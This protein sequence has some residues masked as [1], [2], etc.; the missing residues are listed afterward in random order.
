[1]DLA[2][3]A[4]SQTGRRNS[5]N[6]EQFAQHQKH[7]EYVVVLSQLDHENDFLSLKSASNIILQFELILKRCFFEINHVLLG[8]QAILPIIY[9]AILLFEFIQLLFFIFY[10]V[11]VVNEFTY[12]SYY[13]DLEGVSNQTN[14]STTIDADAKFSTFRIDYYFA[15]TNFHMYILQQQSKDAFM[16]FHIVITV[17]FLLYVISI[18]TLSKQIFKDERNDSLKEGMKYLVKFFSILMTV[19]LFILQI[20]MITIYLQG[21]LCEEDESQPYTLIGLKCYSL[22]HQLYIAFSTISLCLYILFLIIQSL[23]FTSNS[24]E[25]S[26]PWGSL[27]RRLSIMRVLVK[28]ILACCF[29]WDKQ[30]K[31]RGP[32]NLVCFILCSFLVYHRY[33][34]AIVFKQSVYYAMMI[35]EVQQMWLFLCISVHILGDQKLNIVGFGLLMISGFIFG[36]IFIILTK[37][38]TELMLRKDISQFKHVYEIE[39]YLF[40]I[41]ELIRNNTTND[42]FILHGILCNHMQ[43]CTNEKCPCINIME[44][45]DN[46]KVNQA[47]GREPIMQQFDNDINDAN[48]DKIA[49]QG[50]R[51]K[52]NDQSTK[53]F[54]TM[55]GSGRVIG[56]QNRLTINGISMNARTRRNIKVQSQGAWNDKK[57]QE[58]ALSER[59]KKKQEIQWYRFLG[60]LIE[61]AIEKFPKNLELKIINALIQNKK[62]KNEFKAI[63]EL[64]NCE[65][66]N[67]N[68][69]DQFVIF[70]RKIQ[71]ELLLKKNHQKNILEIGRIDIV[72][73]FKYE[74]YFQQYSLLEYKTAYAALLFWR[75]LLQKNV[76]SNVLQERGAEISENYQKIQELANKLIQIYPLEIKFYFR[77]G[78]FLYQ[79]INNAYDALTYFEKIYYTYHGKMSKKAIPVNEMSIFGENSN[80]AIIMISATS[81]KTGNIIHVNDEVETILGYKKQEL[82]H[83]NVSIMMPKPIAKIHDKFIDRYFDTAQPTVIDI[84]RQLFGCTNTG[85]LRTIRLLVKVYPHLSSRL[86][87]V[88]FIQHMDKFE[89]MAQPKLEYQHADFQ[90]LITDTDQNITNVTEGLNLE[91]GLNSKFFQ[92]SDS[93]FEILFNFQKICPEITQE[94]VQEALEE[95]GLILTIDTKN[96]LNHIELESLS[97]DEILEIRSKLGR[98]E[99]YVQMKSLVLDK[100]FCTVHIY[101]ICILNKVNESQIFSSFVKAMVSRLDEDPTD[102]GQISVMQGTASAELE[103]LI[104]QPSQLSL[105]STTSGTYG[106]NKIIKDFKKALG[107]RKTPRNLIYLNRLMVLF[108]TLNMIL[109]GVDFGLKQSNIENYD[110]NNQQVL[111]IQNRILA[112]IHMVSNFRSLINIANGVEFDYYD[113]RLTNSAND[114][115]MTSNQTLDRFKYLQRTILHNSEKLQTIHEFITQQ[116][117]SKDSQLDISNLIREKENEQIQL[118]RI[119]NSMNISQYKLEFRVA[120]NLYLNYIQD[121]IEINNKTGMKIPTE[122]LKALPKNSP[123]MNK[124]NISINDEQKIIY[125]LLSNGFRDLRLFTYDLVQYY[126]NHTNTD[127]SGKQSMSIMVVGIITSLVCT[128]ILIYQ[129]VIIERNKVSILSL[130][131]LLQIDEITEVHGKCD[132]F[133]EYLPYSHIKPKNNENN[134]SIMISQQIPN[135]FTKTGNYNASTTFNATQ[136]FIN[137]RVES[138]ISE[139]EKEAEVYRQFIMK[140]RNTKKFKA[141]SRVNQLLKEQTPTEE[142]QKAIIRKTLEQVK[143]IQDAEQLQYELL[144]KKRQKDMRNRG[145][146]V[147]KSSRKSLSTLNAKGDQPK[148]QDKN[149]NL[150]ATKQRVDFKVP[151]KRDIIV[152]DTDSNEGADKVNNND[153]NLEMKD[154]NKFTADELQERTKSFQKQIKNVGY[155]KQLRRLGFGLTFIAYFIYIQTFQVYYQKQLSTMISSVSIFFN[156]YSNLMLSFNIQREQMLNMQLSPTQNLSTIDSLLAFEKSR[157]EDIFH[158]LAMNDQNKVNDLKVSYP[159]VLEQI[160]SL[161][162]DTDS[163]EFCNQTKAYALSEGYTI[164]DLYQA[165]LEINGYCAAFQEGLLSKGIQQVIGTFNKKFTDQQI[166][167]EQYSN[168]QTSSK[169]IS[170]YLKAILKGQTSQNDQVFKQYFQV[171]ELYF[172]D[173][174][175]EMT[176]IWQTAFQTQKSSIVTITQ[177]VFFIFLTLLLILLFFV[178]GTMI[179]SMKNKVFLSRG[180][181]NLIPENFFDKNKESVEK[182]IKKLKN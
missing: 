35:Y 154:S 151:K 152:D 148:A 36:M 104:N 55:G 3:V 124:T 79:I 49:N 170:D 7:S 4:S 176:K 50:Q 179:Q 75:E 85:Y 165:R 37:R 18:I 83:K 145:K 57:P 129:V 140:K 141:Q 19:F 98:Y 164:D 116:R 96:M 20:P 160:V 136:G 21:Y 10:K 101:R 108:L 25:S 73:I 177:V 142:K 41:Y 138:Q 121:I 115:L 81:R 119:Q 100:S 52:L 67:P 173:I 71:I 117:F 97:S 39:I 155:F 40:R 178:R 23:L 168:S 174:I 133:L 128:F 149:H 111:A 53:S 156:R 162:K 169:V 90:Y 42:H 123:N 106:F 146:V 120:F 161:I 163:T 76:D 84:K 44:I 147:K 30:G 70:R 46:V 157:I 118:N 102:F 130:Y 137:G 103:E 95:E 78:T 159:N 172:Y 94:E 1:M 47:D 166:L 132:E 13:H 63:F 45:Q 5:R 88:G 107:E 68:F 66:C 87:F 126:Q 135:S 24:F 86:V 112:Y 11:E 93:I 16:M 150:S 28:F 8:H 59:K 17:S 22:N 153:I 91:L 125:F 65:L 2:S 167:L 72:Q 27:E 175:E 122:L 33:M 181:L 69:Q 32:V 158:S 12:S 15:F 131:G 58:K 134:Q 62:I 6:I 60:I 80:C 180:I 14:S 114:W 109:S 77:Y 51:R 139:E 113:I 127:Q 171:Q 56:T 82:M 54:N 34:K 110:C 89:D 48:L 182:L 31:I 99:C 143:E 43:S 29:V 26:L 74:K 144:R 92:Y 61:Y 105:S 64:M 38:R 9:H